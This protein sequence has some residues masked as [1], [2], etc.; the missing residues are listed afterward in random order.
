MPQKKG[1]APQTG[2]LPQRVNSNLKLGTHPSQS[3]PIALTFQKIRQQRQQLESRL[4]AIDSQLAI[5]EVN[6]LAALEDYFTGGAPDRRP[7][8]V[9]SSSVSLF[10]AVCHSTAQP[11]SVLVTNRLFDEA[12]A[13]N[14]ST[15]AGPSEKAATGLCNIPET[16]CP[17]SENLFEEQLVRLMGTTDLEVTHSSNTA[18]RSVRRFLRS[19]RQ[20]SGISHESDF[21]LGSQK[22]DREN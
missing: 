2:A 5:F 12:L 4:E 13:S 18:A 19:W 3:N 22:R 6:Y 11:S 1:G 20:R 21:V 16:Q 8:A 9:P 7:T 17:T 10:D 14:R 15:R